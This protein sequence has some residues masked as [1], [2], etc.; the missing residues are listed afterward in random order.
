LDDNEYELI[1]GGNEDFVL[2]GLETHKLEFVV[3]IQIADSVLGL[4]DELRDET[5]ESVA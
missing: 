5:G 3:G 4:A 2:G 1:V